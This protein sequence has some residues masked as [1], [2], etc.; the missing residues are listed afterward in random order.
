MTVSVDAASA[1]PLRDVGPTAFLDWISPDVLLF[2]NRDEAFV[3]TGRDD[4]HAAARA[5]AT[6]VGA[7]V[8]KL[9]SAGAVW[10]DGGH[11]VSRPA[12]RLAASDTTGAGDAF[13]AG[14]LAAVLC[15]DYPGR[16][17]EQANALAATACTIVGGRPPS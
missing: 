3:L 8:V 5:L 2:A 10:S 4:P 17:L 1:S 14:F 7:A 16:A 13:A 15:G 12:R 11:V 9:G 6:A